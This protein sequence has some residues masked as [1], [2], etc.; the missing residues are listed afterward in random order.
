MHKPAVAAA[1][2]AILLPAG[3][4]AAAPTDALQA[5]GDIADSGA[6]LECFDRELARARGSAAPAAVSPA[7]AASP[8]A[9]APTVAAP[10][11]AAPA[12]AAPAAAPQAPAPAAAAAAPPAPTGAAAAAASNTAGSFGE[13]Q[14]KG[15]ARK[16][17]PA[18]QRTLHARITLQDE[19]GSS[20][21]FNVHLDN[22]Q[23]WR[24]ENSHLG[25]YLREGDAVTITK[26][27]GLGAY[28]LTRDAGRD[29]DWIRVTRVR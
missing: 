23:V 27:G 13:E 29:K 17:T 19:L 6:R 12:A 4:Q 3:G 21:I 16:E 18:E 11:A 5:C 7:P 25:S 20:G 15:V 24:H 1:V 2:L 28:R 22:G 14:V 26:V 10:A 8:A 9:T